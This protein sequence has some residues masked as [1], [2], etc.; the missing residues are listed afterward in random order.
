MAASPVL[1]VSYSGV[2]GGAE[3]VLLDAVTRMERPPVVACPDGQLA[4]A[5]RR[6]GIEHAPTSRRPLQRGPAHLKGIA[7]LALDIRRLKPSFVVAWGARAVLAAAPSGRPWLAVHHDLQPNAKLRAALRATTRRA[8]GVVAAS[9]AIARDLGLEQATILHPGVDLDRFSPRPLPPRP[10]RA[11][12]LGALVAWKRP[13]LALEIARHLPELHITIAGTTLPGDDG[14]LETRLRRQAGPQVELA[15]AVADVAGALADA[16]LLLHCADAEPYGMAL[17]E[18]LAAGRPVVAPSAGGPVEIVQDG[19][20]RL[21]PP[22]DAIAAAE[23]I[24][25][26]LQDPDAPAN[27]RRRAE[28]HFDVVASTR[29][30]EATIEA[31]QR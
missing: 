11:L 13:G 21:Y 6:A 4:H 31:A 14:A 24:E 26:I 25:A 29:R 5:L 23:A 10:P 22:G 19:A 27:A 17:V 7:G 15:G 12:V 30:L 9:H 18:A 1:F 20:G 2:L 3:R 28:T 16:H 8:N